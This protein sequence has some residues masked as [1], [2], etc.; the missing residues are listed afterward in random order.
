MLPP[1]PSAPEGTWVYFRA[2]VPSGDEE[3]VKAMRLEEEYDPSSP[4]DLFNK[5][6][7]T[8]PSTKGGMLRHALP[9]EMHASRM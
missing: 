8:T 5:L 1:C 4:L 3:D 2:T 9:E 6:P 7:N